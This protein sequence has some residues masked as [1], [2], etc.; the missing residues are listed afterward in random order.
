MQMCSI[1]RVFYI[2]L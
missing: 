1:T 2:N